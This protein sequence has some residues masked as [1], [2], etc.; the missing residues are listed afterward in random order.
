MDLD[1]LETDEGNAGLHG[2]CP[3]HGPDVHRHEPEP[4]SLIEAQRRK[5]VVRRDEPDP[6]A[7]ALLGQLSHTCEESGADADRPAQGVEGHHL[8]P[9]GGFLEGHETHPFA[10]GLGK[11]S[12][13]LGGFD[14]VP[15]ARDAGRAPSSDEHAFHPVPVGGRDL[16]DFHARSLPHAAGGRVLPRVRTVGM[17]TR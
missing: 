6:A 13:Q 11:Q 4:A 14:R 2:T 7:A 1:A 8:D 12:R 16:A 15:A 3:V 5:V 9:A 10:V 17:M